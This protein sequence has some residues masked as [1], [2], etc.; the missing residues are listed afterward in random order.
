MHRMMR[1]E[2]QSIPMREETKVF[3]EMVA[4]KRSERIL[5]DAPGAEVKLAMDDS[6]L[7]CALQVFK[8]G[9]LEHLEFIES[10]STAGQVK[11]FGD[12]IDVARK[13][14]SLVLLFPESKYTRDMASAI[15]QGIMKE[16]RARSEREVSFQGF[17]FD[18]RGNLKKVS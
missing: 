17:V 3:L 7:R 4:K 6:R 15:Y 8:D 10:E 13:M 18:D 5:K 2:A 9:E 11:Y 1:Q 12:Y 16:V 14:G